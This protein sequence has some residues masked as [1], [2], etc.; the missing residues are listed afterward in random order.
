MMNLVQF[1]LGKISEE[2]GEIVQIS[3]KSQ[4]F[5]LAEVCPGQELTN[6]ERM[7]IEIDDLLA[8]VELLNEIG[9][10]FTSCEK[11]KIR[12]KSKIYHYLKLAVRE[13]MVDPSALDEFP[14]V[15]NAEDIHTESGSTALDTSAFRGKEVWYGDQKATY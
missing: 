12:K 6:A 3:Q 14:F 9:F 7:H 2:S 8:V 5:G 13:G 11:R 15:E 10:E 1:L 4:Q